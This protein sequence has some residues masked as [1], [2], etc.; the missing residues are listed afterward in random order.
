MD[1]LGDTLE[2][3]HIKPSVVVPYLVMSR[4][5]PTGY[6]SRIADAVLEAMSSEGTEGHGCC[7]ECATCLPPG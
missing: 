1:E 3:D 5:A 2:V 7:A 4:S 6:L